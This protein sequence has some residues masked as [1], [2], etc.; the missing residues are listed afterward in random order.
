MSKYSIM[1][2]IILCN[3]GFEFEIFEPTGVEPSER[4]VFRCHLEGPLKP[5]EHHDSMVSRGLRGELNWTPIICKCRFFCS[6][7]VVLIYSN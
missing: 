4:L 3:S 1:Q 6:G 2:I 7:L 5:L